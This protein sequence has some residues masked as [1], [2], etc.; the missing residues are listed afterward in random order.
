MAVITNGNYV[1][2]P[3]A[4]TTMLEK[5]RDGVLY[6]YALKPVDGY[7]LHDKNADWTDVDPDTGEEIYMLGYKTGTVTCAASYDFTANPREF[8]TVLATEVPADQIFGGV[9]P[10]HEVV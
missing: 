10:D 4:N 8:Y 2:S 1:T 3:I 5:L 9:T 6:V 7:V